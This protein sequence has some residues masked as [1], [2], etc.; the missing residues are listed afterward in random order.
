MLLRLET[1]QDLKLLSTAWEVAE[2]RLVLR[3]CYGSLILLCTSFAKSEPNSNLVCEVFAT[4]TRKH[5]NLSI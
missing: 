3:L 5:L 4:G 1:A 2:T